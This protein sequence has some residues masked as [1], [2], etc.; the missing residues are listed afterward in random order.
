MTRLLLALSLILGSPH[1]TAGVSDVIEAIVVVGAVKDIVAPIEESDHEEI[2][3]VLL[4]REIHKHIHRTEWD[5]DF[6]DLKEIR[7]HKWHRTTTCGH[8]PCGS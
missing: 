6:R 4:K 3:S 1:T 2:R 8:P 7:S 5:D